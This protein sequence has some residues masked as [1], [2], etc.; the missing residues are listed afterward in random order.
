M[1]WYKTCELKSSARPWTVMDLVDQK[2]ISGLY[3]VGSKFVEEW[4]EIGRV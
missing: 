3:P 2:E 4:A 1:V